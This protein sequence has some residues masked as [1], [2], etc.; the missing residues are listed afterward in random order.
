MIM[1][2][3]KK[4]I[5]AKYLSFKIKKN[6]LKLHFLRFLGANIHSSVVAIGNFSWVGY[7]SNLKIGKNVTI[8]HGVHLNLSE[9]LIIEDNVRISTNVQFHTGKIIR[10]NKENLHQ[11]NP[12]IIGKNTWI[13]SGAV[14]SSGVKIVSDT[15]ISCNSSVVK[16]IDQPGLYA[17][18]PAKLIRLHKD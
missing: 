17:G 13:A 18:N 5:C 4:I 14:I 3:Y 2:D 7:P 9:K 15:I 8:N 10:V 16:S 11:N 12:I 6:G 1:F